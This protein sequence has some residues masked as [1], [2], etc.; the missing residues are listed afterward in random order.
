MKSRW[1]VR[2]LALLSTLALCLPAALSEEVGEIGEVD[3]YDPS[4]YIEDGEPVPEPE[5]EAAPE[6]TSDAEAEQACELV[7]EM[8][9]A[10][11]EP[12]V[13]PEE[14]AADPEPA[15]EGVAPA[16][17]G[18]EPA[19]GLEDGSEREAVEPADE[20]PLEPEP[21]PEPLLADADA[22]VAPAAVAAD[23][24]MGL[25]E[26]YPLDGK[27]LLGT[28]PTGYVSDHP[29]IVAVDAA[30]GVL[31]G[32]AL[33]VAV[34][35]VTG[36]GASKNYTVQ[37]LAAP[38][39]LAFPS[40]KLTLGKG[41]K[42]PF[43]AMVPDNTGAARIAYT[44]SKSKV[45]SV[46]RQGNLKAKKT[47][48][49]K[50]TA[51]AY[52]GAKVTCTVKVVKAPSKV[53][54]SAKTGV[55]NIGGT[56]TLKATLPKKTASAIL[57]QSSNPG[58]VAVDASGTLTGVGPGTA[59]VT[60][61]TFNNKK[62]SCKITVLDG[63]APTSL[64]LNAETLAL[65]KGEKFQL[66]PALGQGEAAVFAYSSSKKK[67]ASVSS[68]GVITAKKTGTATIKVTTHNGLTAKVK[69]K[70]GKAPSKIKLSATKLTLK[71]GQTAQLQAIL[72]SGA[73]SSLVWES[74]NSAVATV[75]GNGLVTALK[76]GTA[77]ISVTAFNGRSASCALVVSDVAGE[78]IEI[79]ASEA[80]ASVSQSAAQML[81]NLRKSSVLGSKKEAVLN[82]MQLLMANGF[83]PAFAAGVAANILAEGTYG[84]FE[85][86]KYI[87][88]YQ[89]RPKYF[90]YLDGGNYYTL[91][92][93]KY[94]LT[95]VYLSQEELDAYTGTVEARLRF[96]EEN[97]YRDHY[98]GRHVQ[99]VNLD[100]L[101]A[102]LD[103]LAAGKWQGKFGVGI[104]QWT[105]ARTR[106]LASFYRK[107][108]GSGS[109]ITAAQ[110]AAAENEMILYDFK[111]SYAGVYT[112]WRNANK[113]NLA[114]E[115]AARSAGSIV[116]LKYE[117]PASKESKA[118]TRGNKAAE[119]Y[120][121]MAGK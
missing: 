94:V 55:M 57:W 81:A 72:P 14:P 19:E 99:A 76:G 38:D 61:R 96:G 29:E 78:S 44:S 24:C 20:S 117:V 102:F 90:C 36:S 68:K 30:T 73:A 101:Q 85:S 52:N 21:T 5:P 16:D 77:A 97:Y 49:A 11:E 62:A 9:A 47:G 95:A 50:I 34:I 15:D 119:I 105:G 42:R 41:E 45:V 120:R 111:G 46:D 74:S 91:K 65:G 12:A 75:D 80:S 109:S 79:P 59:T 114:S 107:H 103:T 110:V 86:S 43:A 17:E 22:E 92:D 3:L 40:G 93:G 63:A 118:V 66:L 106:T 28:A 2:I 88:N 82:V 32:K 67:V 112:S 35:A 33:G 84:L 116:C 54:L 56:R 7:V 4:I 69:V 115:A 13:E 108:A 8:E 37:V 100:E 26:Q 6:A 27:A 48:T 70:V 89:K 23:L 60:A 51:A 1:L 39:K 98:S 83:E 10:A 58:V 87:A 121:A 104:V 64:T 31:T 18:T 53:K 25:G 71:A 113:G